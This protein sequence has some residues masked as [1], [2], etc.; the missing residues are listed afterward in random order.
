MSCSSNISDSTHTRS[1]TRTPEWYRKWKV[2]SGAFIQ[3]TAEM[4]NVKVFPWICI[5]FGVVRLVAEGS[6]TGNNCLM[7]QI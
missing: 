1:E 4:T 5:P 3:K 2:L 7:I 6:P